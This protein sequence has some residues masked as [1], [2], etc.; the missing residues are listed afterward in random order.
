LQKRDD[1]DGFLKEGQPSIFSYTDINPELYF[2]R[3]S[4]KVAEPK[5]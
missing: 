4:W 1:A 5:W 2:T 3:M